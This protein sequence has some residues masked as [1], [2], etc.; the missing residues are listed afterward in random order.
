MVQNI[1]KNQQ[2]KGEKTARKDSNASINS[3]TALFKL[4]LHWSM[5]EYTSPEQNI[6]VFVWL[7][8]KQWHKK[9]VGPPK[10]LFSRKR[11][12]E[13]IENAF[14]CSCMNDVQAQTA[15]ILSTK[16][17]PYQLKTSVFNW[18]DAMR[19]DAMQPNNTNYIMLHVIHSFLSSHETCCIRWTDCIYIFRWF[20]VRR[21]HFF[22]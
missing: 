13:R 14:Q 15:N 9:S 18:N 17:Y 21:M 1:T 2:K 8:T 4:S 16:F 3:S 20:F 5:I 6:H 7:K 10:T 19:C 22:E 11:Y 12:A